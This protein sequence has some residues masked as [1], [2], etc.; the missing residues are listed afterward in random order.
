MSTRSVVGSGV[1]EEAGDI[2]RYV[3]CLE[4]CYMGHVLK[5]RV[6]G[7]KI[8]AVEPDDTINPGI[9]RE[10]GYV[11]DDLIDKQMIITRPCAKGFAKPSYVYDPNRLIYPM[12]RVGEKGE[13]KFERISWDE[14]LDTIAKKM[15]E[16]SNTNPTNPMW[17]T[18]FK[19]EAEM[20]RMSDVILFLGCHTALN[21]FD[22]TCDYCSG[23]GKGCKWLYEQRGSLEVIRFAARGEIGHL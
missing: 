14:A 3:Y 22:I 10:D 11:P 9:A 6:R 16:I 7:G 8:I 23:P 17:K 2:I 15:V 1:G 18:L 20:V 13:G 21:P 12:K 4:H 19:T 5:V